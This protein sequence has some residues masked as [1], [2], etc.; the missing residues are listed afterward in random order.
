MGITPP[1]PT[2]SSVAPS[3]YNTA[4]TIRRELWESVDNKVFNDN[5]SLNWTGPFK[6]IAVGHSSIADTPNVR[7]IRDRLL[8]LNFSILSDPAPKP[9]VTVT[10]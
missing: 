7:P 2:P 3:T 9:S 6:I 8:H 4:N 1:S 10:R 5:L